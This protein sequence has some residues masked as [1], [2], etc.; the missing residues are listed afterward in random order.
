M[1]STLEHALRRMES[2]RT[3]FVVRNLDG[4]AKR[5]G[6]TCHAIERICRRAGLPVRYWHT[7]RHS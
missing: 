3:G 6:E 5:D 2:V 7:L 1:T 4:S